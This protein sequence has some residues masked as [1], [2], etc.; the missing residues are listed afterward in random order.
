MALPALTG[1]AG[2]RFGQP[3][4]PPS[5]VVPSPCPCQPRQTLSG[6]A[7]FNKNSETF[8]LK[9]LLYLEEPQRRERPLLRGGSPVSPSPRHAGSPRSSAR[10]ARRCSSRRK[11]PGIRGHARSAGVP[12]ARGGRRFRRA[13]PAPAAQVGHAQRWRSPGPRSARAGWLILLAALWRRLCVR[14]ASPLPLAP[15][16]RGARSRPGR[17]SPAAS[18]PE[19]P[20]SAAMALRRLGA[21]LLL[22]P[23]L[24]AVEGERAG[25]R[26]GRGV[27]GHPRPPAPTSAP[28][29][30]KFAPGLA[31]G[32]GGRGEVC[33]AA[34]G[35]AGPAG[36]RGAAGAD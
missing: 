23:L 6:F 12:G 7:A 35:G 26:W 16:A 30:A 29:P 17:P 18:R 20:G 32:A 21:A 22:L 11:Q 3:L 24:A 36:A 9:S 8:G 10:A 19:A 13:P 27:A 2:P 28:R 31:P 1:R 33:P 4:L 14:R 15:R 25:G 5:P 34:P